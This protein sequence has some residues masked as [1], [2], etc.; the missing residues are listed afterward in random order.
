MQRFSQGGRVSRGC[1]FSNSSKA[2][3]RAVRSSIFGLFWSVIIFP[4]SHPIL[5]YIKFEVFRWCSVE[6]QTSLVSPD[7]TSFLPSNSVD[8]FTTRPYPLITKRRPFDV[9]IEYSSPVTRPI[10]R[11]SAIDTPRLGN[12]FV[13]PDSGKA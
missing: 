6:W 10:A 8:T 13:A 1:R 9:H 4:P 7:A 5:L 3:P 11:K 2:N 12:T